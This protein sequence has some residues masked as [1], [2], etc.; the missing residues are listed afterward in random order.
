MTYLLGIDVSTT[1]T[2]A[3]LVDERGKTVAVAASEY[4]LSTPRP[5]WAEQDPDLWWRAAT[6]SIGEVLV[7]SGVDREA[8]VAVGLTGQAWC[9][10]PASD[11]WSSVAAGC[12]RF[13][14]RCWTPGT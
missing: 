9:S 3:V 1:A 7:N 14:T 12:M 8:I 13:L 6:R 10:P 11:L 5:L 4:E 2:K